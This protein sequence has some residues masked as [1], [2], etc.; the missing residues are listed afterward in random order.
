MVHFE[1]PAVQV[2]FKSLFTVDT[3][4]CH[5]IKFQSVTTPD[6]LIALLYGPVNGNRHDSFMLQ[7]S[8]LIPQLR[9]LFPVGA[10]QFSLYGDPAY[11]QSDIFL[12]D[13]GVQLLV[14]QKRT[15]IQKCQR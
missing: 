5:G 6:G 7:E 12:V 8:A 1:K 13:S 9:A 11:P 2:A 15:G 10:K 3:K 14:L 4:Q